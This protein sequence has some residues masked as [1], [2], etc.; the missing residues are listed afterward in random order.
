LENLKN[1]DN[2]TIETGDRETETGDRRQ[3]TLERQETGR[4]DE[5]KMETGATH[6]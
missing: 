6:G 3:E 4:G 1:V 5:E 2:A